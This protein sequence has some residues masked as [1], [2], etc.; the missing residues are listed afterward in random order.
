[1]EKEYFTHEEI[2]QDLIDIL[3]GFSGEYAVLHHETFNTDYYLIGN[4]ECEQ[5][6]ESYGVFDAIREVQAWEEDVTG[7]TY[8]EV[9]AFKIANMLYYI[10]AEAFMSEYEPFASLYSEVF[11]LVATEENNAILIEALKAGD[12]DE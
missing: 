7:E 10:K 4:Y 12:L 9:N 2:K 3:D 5:A 1:M 6:L 8:T 11:D